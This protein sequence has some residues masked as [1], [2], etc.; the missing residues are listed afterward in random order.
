M[1]QVFM[2]RVLYALVVLVIVAVITF[3][4]M[5]LIPGDPVLVMLGG[6]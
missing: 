3:T 2:K 5:R 1:F 4:L 6:E